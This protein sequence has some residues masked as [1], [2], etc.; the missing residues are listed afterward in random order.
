[1]MSTVISQAKSKVEQTF[2][3]MVKQVGSQN[4]S[5]SSD[6]NNIGKNNHK[7]PPPAKYTSKMTPVAVE[8]N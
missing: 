8:N 4:N 1:M 3:N 6:K 7:L 2:T 5:Q